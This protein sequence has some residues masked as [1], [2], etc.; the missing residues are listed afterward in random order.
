M[1]AAATSAASAFFK[2]S[3]I[4]QNYI[5]SNANT[6]S[7][8][9]GPSSRS[10]SPAPPQTK[11]APFSVGLWRVQEAVHKTNGKHVSVWS[12]DKKNSALDKLVA[13]AKERVMQ[14]L[15]TEV[16]NISEIIPAAT[17][18]DFPAKYI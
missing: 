3:A 14:V 16:C 18:I 17:Q 5:L 12:F 8:A 10:A 2:V 4:S 1:L 11:S 9:S 6:T 7:I 13:A 15:K